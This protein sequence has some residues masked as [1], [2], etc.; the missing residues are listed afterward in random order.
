M[1]VPIQ[2]AVFLPFSKIVKLFSIF[3]TK[4]PF[5]SCVYFRYIVSNL[6]H[7]IFNLPD[8]SNK[9]TLFSKSFPSIPRAQINQWKVITNSIN[10]ISSSFRREGLLEHEIEV[11]VQSDQEK[12]Q[13]VNYAR[14][15]CEIGEFDVDKEMLAFVQKTAVL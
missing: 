9:W 11:P 4:D 15:Q 1:H 8:T 6:N 13:I 14:K 2:N 3:R 7:L 10:L 5:V 12:I